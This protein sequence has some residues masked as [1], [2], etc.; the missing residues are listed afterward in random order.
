[1]TDK[2]NMRDKLRSIPSIGAEACDISL[3]RRVGGI[4]R[5]SKLSI[6]SKSCVTLLRCFS[7]RAVW[8]VVCQQ[9]QVVFL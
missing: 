3:S 7:V 6:R 8:W 2:R 9:C 4:L 1:M 5:I